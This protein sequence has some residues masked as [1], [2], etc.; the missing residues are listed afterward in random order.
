MIGLHINEKKTEYIAY[1]HGEVEKRAPSEQFSK[2]KEHPRNNSQ[3][4]DGF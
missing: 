1:K 2:K 4:S 3:S